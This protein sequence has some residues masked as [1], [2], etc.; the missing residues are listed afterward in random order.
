VCPQ[1]E[2]AHHARHGA[3]GAKAGRGPAIAVALSSAFQA[4]AEFLDEWKDTACLPDHL[5]PDRL[6][7]T[8]KSELMPTEK[9]PPAGPPGEP[10]WRRP[11]HVTEIGQLG[12]ARTWAAGQVGGSVEARR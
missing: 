1:L 5:R 2:L 9:A 7:V 3:S 8:P 11:L 10:E 4:R 6:V 12:A